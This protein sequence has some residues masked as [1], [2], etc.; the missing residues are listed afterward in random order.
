MAQSRSGIEP[1]VAR[2]SR[3]SHPISDKIHAGNCLGDLR[4]S[5]RDFLSRAVEYHSGHGAHGVFVR[6][7]ESFE[8]AIEILQAR[9]RVAHLLKEDVLSMS[10]LHDAIDVCP[11]DSLAMV[12]S[13]RAHRKTPRKKLRLGP[14]RLS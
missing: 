5:S 8:E 4:A 6:N 7:L 10:R 1:A 9:S 12:N 3:G 13:R 11:V 2:G 14:S